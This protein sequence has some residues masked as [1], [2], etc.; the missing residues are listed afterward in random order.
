[1]LTNEQKAH[2]IA[3]ALMPIF[4]DYLKNNGEISDKVQKLNLESP[5][6]GNDVLAEYGVDLFSMYI[7]SYEM[8]LCELEKRKD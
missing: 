1:M 5:G 2:D 7:N 8:A 4:Y 6:K 3:I